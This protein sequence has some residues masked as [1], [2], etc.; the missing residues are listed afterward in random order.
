MHPPSVM[1]NTID[2]GEEESHLGMMIGITDMMTD[3]NEE[4]VT[5]MEDNQLRPT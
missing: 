2:Q 3:M 4:E 1:I 5:T